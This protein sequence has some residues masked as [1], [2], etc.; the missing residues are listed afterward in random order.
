MARTQESTP[1][2]YHGTDEE[3]PHEVPA[4]HFVK[5]GEQ[6]WVDLGTARRRLE[7]VDRRRHRCVGGQDRF[8]A[9]GAAGQRGVVFDIRYHRRV[10]SYLQ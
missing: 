1:N 4:K 6:R 7:A 8:E 10:L 3:P 2:S 5:N 9:G